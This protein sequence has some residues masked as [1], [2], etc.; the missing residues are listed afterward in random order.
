MS[1]ILA[2]AAYAISSLIAALLFWAT[3]PRSTQP[4][5]HF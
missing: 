5:R 4:P 1:I 2:L 3:K